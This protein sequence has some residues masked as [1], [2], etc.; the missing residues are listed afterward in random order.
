MNVTT[1]KQ[2]KNI[3]E[4]LQDIPLYTTTQDSPT[5][6]DTQDTSSHQEK[7]S[8]QTKDTD[9]DFV[10]SPGGDVSYSF[11]QPYNLHKSFEEEPIE[12]V[13]LEMIFYEMRVIKYDIASKI[14][15]VKEDITIKLQ[16]QNLEMRRELDELKQELSSKSK[17]IDDLRT[18]L[19]QVGKGKVDLD[20]V[21]TVERQNS[22]LQQ[23]IRRNN[24]EIAGIPDSVKQNELESKVIE[25]AKAVNIDIPPNEI[26]ACHRLFQRKN[27]KGPKRTIV[28]FVNRKLAEKLIKKGKDFSKREVFEKA[29]LTNKIY[30]NNNLC[31]Y[32]RF[33]WG[34]VKALYGR[35]AIESFWV[36]NGSINLRFNDDTDEVLKVTHLND[37][38]EFFPDHKDL[39]VSK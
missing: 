1:R 17:I 20:D 22:E 29:D 3:E 19:D 11:S 32:Y 4:V 27:Q 12:G 30:I 38:I 15:S 8:L 16:N 25:I 5:Q 39:F 13:T 6:K 33:L 37:L 28:R 34:R 23:Y 18:E 2:Q 35:N 36:F 10:T 31:S 21:S 24:I 9:K 14:E 26:E 7:D